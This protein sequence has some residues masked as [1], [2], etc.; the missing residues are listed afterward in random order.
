[1]SVNKIVLCSWCN[2]KKYIALLDHRKLIMSSKRV[3]PGACSVVLS[4]DSTLECFHRCHVG[5]GMF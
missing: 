1:M 5:I 4:D 3:E 2:G